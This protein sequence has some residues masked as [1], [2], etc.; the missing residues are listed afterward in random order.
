LD[1]SEHRGFFFF[2]LLRETI[3]KTI[4][5]KAKNYLKKYRQNLGKI[6]R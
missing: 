2:S 3:K 6:F 5:F 1:L 4:P